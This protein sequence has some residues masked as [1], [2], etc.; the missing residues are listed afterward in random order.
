MPTASRPAGARL[1]DRHRGPHPRGARRRD[2][3]EQQIPGNPATTG[4]SVTATVDPAAP[5]PPPGWTAR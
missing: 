4:W 1:A 3:L 2:H 5:R